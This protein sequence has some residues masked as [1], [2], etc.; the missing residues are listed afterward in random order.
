M[1][2]QKKGVNWDL[3]SYFPEFNGPEMKKFNENLNKD[4]AELQ[5]KAGVL[6]PLSNETAPKWE[7]IVLLAENFE[8]RLGH[9]FSYIRC[10]SAADAA[11]EEYSQEEGRL[12][13]LH[14]EYEKLNVDL[15]RAFKGAPDDVFDAFIARDALRGAEH[16]IK[17]IREL[18]EYTMSTQEEKLAADLRVDGFHSW[19]RLYDKITGKLE[20][21]MVYPDGRREKK[22]ISQWRSLMS[23]ADRE[24]GKAA[25]ECG[26]KAWASIEDT[27]ATALNSISGTRLTLNKYRGIDHFLDYA[28]FQASIKRETL[29]AM[30]QAISDNIE[31]GRE[32]FRSKAKFMGRDGIWFFEREAPLPLKDAAL[33]SWEE[34]ASMVQNSFGKTF[35]DLAD[36][37]KSF[38]EKKW[39][40]SEPRPGKRPGAFCIGSPVTKEQRVFMTYNGTLSDTTIIAHE[41]GH[42]FHA[43]ILK[44]LRPWA[45]EY[46]MTLAETASI[47]SQLVFAEGILADD[48]VRDTQKL[49]M[50]DADLSSAAILLLDITVR[51][52]FE[53]KFHEKR[54]NGELS[55][56]RFKELMIETQKEVFGDAMLEDSED[57]L[58]WVSKLHFYMTHVT[59]YNFP[60]T[61]GFLLAR[62]LFNLFN[63]EGASFLPKYVKFLQ[64]TGSDT[65]ENV[66]RRS[67][68]VDVSDPAFWAEA[69]K[70][71]EPSLKTYKR[72]LENQKDA[73]AMTG[74]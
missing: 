1:A 27:C 13:A 46:P 70:S 68:G 16:A 73:Q 28:L 44:D 38:L 65:V 17:R 45:K 61:F 18:A 49:L 26:N 19:G 67:I 40:E 25:F 51:F 48:S 33:F 60:Y 12:H 53:K 54:A 22:P 24:V 36:Y 39:I 58:F 29:D 14:A 6:E 23:D 59:F 34:G 15:L 52:E 30:Y 43:H 72:L 57:P 10:L 64:L 5:D 31:I 69:I 2:E 11:N 55:V 56:S 41:V 50:L 66:A 74:F 71:L 7:E 42:A 62:A 4:I 20:F 37:Y 8:A 21:E 35:P 9:I 32:I 63:K 3:A 47:F